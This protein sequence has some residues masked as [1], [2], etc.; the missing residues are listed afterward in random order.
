MRT[1]LVVDDLLSDRHIAGGLLA[2]DSEISVEYAT[3]GVEALEK[4]EARTPDLVLTDLQMPEMGGLDLVSQIRRFY[5]LI[6]TILMTAKGS[7]SH[8]FQALRRGATSYV[9]KKFLGAQLVETVRRIFAASSADRNNARLM[10]CVEKAT[11]VLENDLSLCS[12]LIALLRQS[13][14]HRQI[15]DKSDAIR[16]ATALDEALQNAFYHGN[17]E[18]DSVLRAEDNRPFEELAEKRLKTSPYADRRIRVAVCFSSDEV[19]FSIRDEGPG[20]NPADLPD[21]TNPLYLERPS[22]RGLLLIKHFMDEVKFNDIG[23]EITL[24]KRK[25]QE[26]DPVDQEKE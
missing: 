17:L 22:G 13:V 16:V 12:S 24:V 21:P 2:K 9:P 23:N 6:P 1:V 18:V 7:E 8:A 5:P 11:F 20:F 19:T 10:M 25:S 3:N 14:Q 15:C 4:I 26:F